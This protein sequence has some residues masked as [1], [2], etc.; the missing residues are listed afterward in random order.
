MGLVSEDNGPGLLLTHNGPWRYE[1]GGTGFSPPYVH[2]R[3]PPTEFKDD[4]V[5]QVDN[6]E[7]DIK[8]KTATAFLKSMGVRY[9]KPAAVFCS[10]ELENGLNAFVKEITDVGLFP[11]DDMLRTKAREIM[12]T[13]ITPADDP[14]LLEKFK[15]LH[16]PTTPLSDEELLAE[17][18]KEL[19]RVNFAETGVLPPSSLGLDTI[20]IPATTTSTSPINVNA[21]M[22]GINDIDPGIWMNKDYADLHRV[23][24]ATSS[25]LRRRASVKLARQH[26][27]ENPIGQQAGGSVMDTGVPIPVV[28][29]EKVQRL[30]GSGEIGVSEWERWSQIVESDENAGMGGML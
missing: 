5:V 16:T 8:A 22:T 10:R 3:E 14:V 25:P 17:F 11:T 1:Q 28:Q 12:K 27:F 23:H 20:S 29:R 9:Q 21:T 2:P 6:R 15:A 30:N 13:D 4:V 26:G 7:Y 18:D 24:A 19:E